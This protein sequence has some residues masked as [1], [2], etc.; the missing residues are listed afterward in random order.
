MPLP[1][2]VIQVACGKSHSLVLTKGRT[3][4]IISAC[5]NEHGGDEYTDFSTGGDVLS[6]GLNSH[7]QLGL[8]KNVPR[9]NT[10]LLVCSLTGVAVSTISAGSDY[11][12]FLTLSGLVYCCG[13]NK[14]GQL[15]LNRVDEK[16]TE[17]NSLTHYLSSSTGRMV[18]A[19]ARMERQDKNHSHISL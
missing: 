7:G 8:G 10:P 16:G 1:V 17:I 13:A 3:L 6:W 4:K 15:G 2:P 5:T 9:Q 19:D 11:S 14:V 12:L 18:K